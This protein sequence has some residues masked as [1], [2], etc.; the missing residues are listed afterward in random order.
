[1]PIGVILA[2]YLKTFDGLGATWFHLHRACQSLAFLIG[3]IG[4]VTGIYI[5]NHYGV[6]HTPHKCIGITLMCLASTQ[7]LIAL[8]VRPK[9]DH[10]YRI[11]W[12]I[13]HYIVGYATIALSIFNVLAGFD[14]L[15]A[16][17]IWKKIYVGMIV[18]LA[19]IA[20]MLET[21]TWVRL[22][23]I[24]RAESPMLEASYPQP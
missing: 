20:L 22:C 11:Y 14:I 17:M 6:H 24:K 13:F 1:M 21:I 8:C 12:N 19:I 23:K 7:V 16:H 3:I 5:G 9:K 10:K 2:R 18:S 15:D 4:F